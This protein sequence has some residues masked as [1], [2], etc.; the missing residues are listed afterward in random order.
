MKF[1]VLE[2]EEFE[3]FAVGHQQETFFQTVQNADLRA[4]YGSIIHYFRG[5]GW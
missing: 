1:C 3:N 2:R 4:S 5:E